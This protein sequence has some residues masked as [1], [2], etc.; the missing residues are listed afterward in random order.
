MYKENYKAIY[1]EIKNYST[2]VI[3]RHVGVDPDAMASQIGL[4][5]SIKETFPNK[6]VLAVGNGSIKF[7]YLGKLDKLDE[8]I[9]NAL[10]IVLDTP[11]QK[12]VDGISDFSIFDKTIKIDHHPY[13]ETFCDI[14]HINEK[15]SSTCELIMELLYDTKL[16]CNKDIAEKLFIGL[17]SDTNRFMFANSKPSTFKIVGQLLEDYQFN[18]TELYE[19]L[20]LRPMNEIKLQGYIGQNM[21]VSENGVGYAKITTDVLNEFKADVSSAGNMVNNFNYIEGVYVWVTMTED[22]KNEIIKV[23]IRSRGPVINHI[24]EHY[25][26]GGHPMA[27]GARVKTWNEAEKLINELDNAIKLYKENIL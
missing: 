21:I 15:S 1:K 27:S 14:E 24:A 12:R 16:I 25:I 6:K 4:R 2:I 3:A 8:E 20:Y 26:G 18:I 22:I 11:D 10:L 23:N 13:V 7:T 9:D 17:I 19:K 5:D